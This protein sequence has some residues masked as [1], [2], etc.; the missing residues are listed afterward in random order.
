M[1]NVGVPCNL[2]GDQSAR[3]DRTDHF[4]D[5]FPGTSWIVIALAILTV[6]AC[7]LVPKANEG[8]ETGVSMNLPDEIAG[9][10]GIPL[11]VSQAEHQILPPDTT[12]ARKAY[13]SFSL[14]D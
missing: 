14:P 6:A 4:P 10:E 1:A 13:G 9:L 7:W 12:F 11:P 8:D 2:Q 3:D 5:A